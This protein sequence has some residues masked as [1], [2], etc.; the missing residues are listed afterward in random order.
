M[1]PT[2]VWLRAKLFR[3][4][5]DSSRLLVLEALRDGPLTVGDIVRRT[6]L[7]QPN[8]SMHLACLTECG[9][10]TRERHGR[11]VDYELADKQ[12]VRLLDA[13]EELLLRVAPLI[14]ACPRYRGTDAAGG[15]PAARSRQWRR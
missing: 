6:G 8:A 5:A 1:R 2:E 7:S 11:F 4:L 14:E 13:G 12:V 10:L 15:R 9:L 3:G